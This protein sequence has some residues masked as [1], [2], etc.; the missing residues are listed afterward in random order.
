[1]AVLVLLGVKG[2]SPTRVSTGVGPNRA[3]DSRRVR[4]MRV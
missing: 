1:M 3:E 4:G 2:V